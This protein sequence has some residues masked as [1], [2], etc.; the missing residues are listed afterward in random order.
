MLVN[1]D[2]NRTKIS[3]LFPPIYSTHNL[4]TLQLST[5]HLL[6]TTTSLAIAEGTGYGHATVIKLVRSHADKLE[7]FGNI[8]F[9]I[10]NSV[11]AGRHTQYALLTEPQATLLLTF[12]RNNPVVIR[13]KVRL[14]EEFYR[15]R[16]QLKNTQT[17]AQLS[18]ME[19]LLQVNH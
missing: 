16:E 8:G 1:T 3:S 17:P 14:V 13:F 6:L 2:K 4:P 15:M 10:Q 12:M 7:Q 9:E 11:G 18:R 5:Q 19:I